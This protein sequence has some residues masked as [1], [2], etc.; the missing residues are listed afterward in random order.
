MPDYVRE[1]SKAQVKLP[2]MI[3]TK[4]RKVVMPSV[5]SAAIPSPQLTATYS[6]SIV[7]FP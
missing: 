6:R 1:Y 4:R 7:R 3:H 2:P 5:S